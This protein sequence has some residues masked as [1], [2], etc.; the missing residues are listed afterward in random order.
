M[1]PRPTDFQFQVARDLVRRLDRQIEK[2]ST[3]RTREGVLMV[4]KLSAG[5]DALTAV[6]DFADA[7][8]NQA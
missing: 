6:I 7:A 5:R 2:W 1:K 8:G 3:V 4:E